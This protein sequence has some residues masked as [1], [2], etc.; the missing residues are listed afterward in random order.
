MRLPSFQQSKIPMSDKPF[1]LSSWLTPEEATKAD[2]FLYALKWKGPPPSHAVLV[3]TAT[4]FAHQVPRE[5][6][7]S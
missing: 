7:I 5:W 3:R 6:P 2:A 1:V 4:Y